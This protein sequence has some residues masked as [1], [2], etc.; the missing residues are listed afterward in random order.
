ITSAGKHELWDG[1]W[2]VEALQIEGGEKGFL[3]VTIINVPNQKFIT[4]NHP[5]FEK[6]PWFVFATSPNTLLFYD[7]DKEMHL[8]TLSKQ[9][10]IESET[11]QLPKKWGVLLDKQR[12]RPPVMIQER[13]ADGKV[14]LR[15]AK[16]TDTLKPYPGAKDGK[17]IPPPNK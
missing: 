13:G 4:F 1:Q 14:R 9:G 5:F 2:K 10:T 15:P 17:V 12:P 7:G 16:P 6:W 11:T 8:V 3:R